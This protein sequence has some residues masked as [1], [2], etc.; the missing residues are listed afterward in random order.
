MNLTS[1][2]WHLVSAGVVT[3]LGTFL[4]PRGCDD[5]GGVSSWERCTSAM[6]ARPTFSVEDWGLDSNFNILI[7]AVTTALDEL[8][9][10]ESMLLEESPD[11]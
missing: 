5:V 4:I 2:K 6:G 11:A 8:V 7:P 10:G 1:R 9:P 3:F